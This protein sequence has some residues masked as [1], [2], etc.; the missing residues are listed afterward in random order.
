[1]MYGRTFW[2]VQRTTFIVDPVGKVAKVLGNVKPATHDQLVL[3]ALK[4]VAPP[5]V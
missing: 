1:M 2:G 4:E 5:V 3:G